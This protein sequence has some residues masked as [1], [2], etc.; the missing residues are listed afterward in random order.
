MTSLFKLR[1]LLV[2]AGV[3]LLALFIWYGGP[4]I[5]FGSEGQYRPLASELVRLIVIALVIVALVISHLL[6]RL[7]ANKNSDNLMAAVV[8]QSQGGD[9]RPSAEA[10]QLRE[11][12]EE[13]VAALKQKRRSGHTL[14]E[15][16]WYVIIGAPG[17]GKTTALVNSGLKFPIEQRSGKGA[18]RGV[19]GTR[20]CDWW[21][22]DDAVLIDTAGRYTTQ[23]SDAS[24]DSAA[25]SEF[26]A[27][28]RKYRGRR[29]ING[30]ILTISA[31]DLMVQSASA[32]ET[33]VDAARRRLDELNRELRMRLPVYLMVTKC[34]LVAGFTEYFDDQAQQGRSQIWGVT[35]AYDD[36][37]NGRAA[38][39]FP[40]EFDSLI[41]RLNERLLPRLEEER[42]VRRRA[43]VFGFPQQMAALRESL[44]EFVSEV[45]SAT[46]FDKQ[47]LLRGVYFTSGTQEGTPIDRL[48]GALSRQ[49]A[50]AESAV[51]AGGRGK[52]YFIERLLMDVVF[53]ESGL[54][55]VN[56]RVEVQKAALQLSAY[57]A[58]LL[59]GV[60]GLIGLTTSYRANRNYLAGVDQELRDL[61][62]AGGDNVTSLDAQLPR[63]DLIRRV[64]DSANRYNDRTPWSMG[65]GLYQ[66]EAVGE[67]ARDAYARALNGVF[68]P[69][70]TARFK[71]RLTTHAAEPEKLYEY[72]KGYLMLGDP[73]RLDREQLQF[74]AEQ[75]WDASYGAV[76]D[77]RESVAKHFRSLLDSGKLGKRTLDETIVAQTRNTLLQASKAGLVY[78]YVRLNYADDPARALRL[79]VEAGIGAE[80]VLRRKSGVPLS[81][82]LPS[83]YT[84]DVFNEVVTKGMTD[85]VKRFAAEQWVWGKDAPS[86][87]NSATLT[88]EVLDVYEK[89]Y[90]AFWDRIFREID[91]V[92]M[93]A[94]ANAKESLAILSGPTSPLR[95]I[96][97]A[98]D[99]HT[100]LVGPQEAAPK[101]AASGVKDR[102]KN[103]F[104]TAAPGVVVPTTK[105]GN[106]ITMHFAEIHRL[107]TGDAGAAPIDG[108]LRTMQQMQQK[109][110]P[111][112]QNVGESAADA[113]SLR[114]I[115]DLSNSLKRD[116]ALLPAPLGAVIT[117]IASGSLSA[118]RGSGSTV[119]SNN[120]EQAVLREC[121]VLVNG[122]YPFE[123]G[124][125]SDIPI[126]D[127][128]RLFGPNGVYDT[129]FKSDLQN[130]VSRA[131]SPWTW[132]TDSSGAP[133]GSGIPLAKFEAAERIR[134]IF[135]RGASPKF[136]ISF[137]VT[138]L[139]L[140]PRESSASF[141]LEIDGQRIPY[142]FGPERPYPVTWPGPKPGQATATFSQ[143]GGPNA[144]FDGPWAWFRLID[145]AQLT[146]QG[147]ERYLLIIKRGTREAQLRIEA[148]SVLNP[149]EGNDL[150]RFRCE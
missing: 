126:A 81:M 5:A 59:V 143:S 9:A 40:T 48:L 50:I 97:K 75:E 145:S 95:G 80:K 84:K 96:L 43:K 64:S 16:P 65:W 138:P 12:F 76:P 133:V 36:T 2:I 6:K 26:L 102:L 30:V 94:M 82:P 120:Y 127:F 27:L 135:F 7:R 54:A 39:T 20:N 111:I 28:L 62:A 67:A 57:V 149:F 31:Q 34:D 25:W 46:R 99:K 49:F 89:D 103:I 119:V 137:R 55:G 88:Q 113:N 18:L 144:A 29:P 147:D 108:V 106:Q 74:L 98:I 124:S 104:G 148:D 118:V 87:S 79:D 58:M 92:P 33:H 11:R 142:Q 14:Y 22:T 68:L 114:D 115:G 105:P 93:G 38:Q 42:D 61:R 72:L 73:A 122:R 121:R 100:Y 60:I 24:A 107:V 56:R 128:E 146:R 47:L 132:L 15:L 110:A 71:Q 8:K 116:A 117:A 129:F 32:R 70:V 37:M 131:R 21:F 85:L 78:R 66:G 83:L 77:T 44:S 136:E 1:T 134:Q 91:T 17:S 86:L 112:G 150:Q 140:E 19:G 53:A 10:Q 13:A 45:F 101:D 63:L 109:M 23:D 3:V 41:A 139:S 4:L 35:F 125:S 130:R 69:Q 141:A 51:S 52:A 90:I 123:R